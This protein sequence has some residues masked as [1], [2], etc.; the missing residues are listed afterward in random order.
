MGGAPPLP[1]DF[2]PQGAKNWRFFAP[3]GPT[4]D[5]GPEGG[6]WGPQDVSAGVTKPPWFRWGPELEPGC[7]SPG[8]GIRP[9]TQQLNAAAGGDRWRDTPMGVAK[10][11]EYRVRAKQQRHTDALDATEVAP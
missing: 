2:A 10:R 3:F 1:H 8:R 5:Q 4:E 6:F 9:Q 11:G 7:P